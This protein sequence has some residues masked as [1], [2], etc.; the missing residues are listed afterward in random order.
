MRIVIDAWLERKD[1]CI[2]FLDG[3]TAAPVMQWGAPL[4]RHLLERGDLN[5]DELQ[6]RADAGLGSL[7]EFLTAIPGEMGRLGRG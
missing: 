6:R 5:L 1:P 4:I 2:R 3:D 7:Y